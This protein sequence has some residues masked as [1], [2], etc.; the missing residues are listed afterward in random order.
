MMGACFSKQQAQC[1]PR[2]L[3]KIAYFCGSDFQTKNKIFIKW[4]S[5]TYSRSHICDAL[6]D[7]IHSYI[8]VL[9][10]YFC[11]RIKAYNTDSTSTKKANRK[12]LRYHLIHNCSHD[13]CVLGAR[14]SPNLGNSGLKSGVHV[15][16]FAVQSTGTGL[17]STFWGVQE[18]DSD[19]WT[20]ILREKSIPLRNKNH[21]IKKHHDGYALIKEE[22]TEHELMG[23]ETAEGVVKW[24]DIRAFAYAVFDIKLDLDGL[25]KMAYIKSVWLGQGYYPVDGFESRTSLNCLVTNSNGWIPYINIKCGQSV[26]ISSIDPRFY[27]LRCRGIDKFMN[28]YLCDHPQRL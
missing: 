4:Y 9:I 11:L 17:A 22:Q 28:S 27:G 12:K 8:G 7:I 21:G 2:S 26:M 6:V 18:Y 24:S 20:N 13:N 14:L 19:P 5:E 1:I 23:T 15:F 25:N 16:R 10:T 3:G